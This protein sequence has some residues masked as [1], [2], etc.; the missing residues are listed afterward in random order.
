MISGHTRA[1]VLLGAQRF[2]PTLGEAVAELKVEGKI[3][4]ITAGWQEREEEDDDLREH[5]GG[6]AVNLKLHKRAEEAF[7]DDA[8]LM[9]A[10]RERQALLRHRQDFYRI[11]MEHAL[12]AQHVIDNRKAPPDILEDEAR[13][14]IQAIRDID[15]MHLERCV[16]DRE[17]FDAKW[18]PLTRPA[19]ARHVAELAEIMKDCDAIAIAGGHVASLLNR[20]RLFDIQN[21]AKGKFI[22]AWCAGAMAISERVVIFHHSPPQGPAAVEVLDEGLGLAGDVVVLPQPELRLKLDDRERIQTMARRF[23]PATCLAMPARSRVTWRRRGPEHAH[24]VIA[25]RDDG[26]HVRFHE[27]ES[28]V[29]QHRG[30]LGS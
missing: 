28:G 18:K 10:H 3:A 27:T 9:E 1:I 11:R 25:L 22:F 8:E 24:G 23:A 15:R 20:L 16:R 14:S 17:E 4:T 30:V 29:F 2:D 13:A 6:R 12:E 26:M 5:L 19:I 21:F 7:R